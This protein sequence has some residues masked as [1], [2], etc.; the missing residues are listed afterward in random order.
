MSPATNTDKQDSDLDKNLSEPSHDD[1][2]VTSDRAYSPHHRSWLMFLI[3]ILIAFVFAIAIV[4]FGRWAYHRV[5]KS[6][7]PASTSQ[8]Q[9]PATTPSTSSTAPAPTQNSNS[10]SQSS[11]SSSSSTSAA[12][13]TPNTGPG[14][15]IALFIGASVLVGGLHYVLSARRG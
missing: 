11:N 1:D 2:L 3:Y 12:T 4:L 13:Q 15:V 14:N 5:H 6:N 7:Q 9:K 8:T 10:T